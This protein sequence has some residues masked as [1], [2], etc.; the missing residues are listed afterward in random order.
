MC[1]LGDGSSNSCSDACGR[2]N[3]TLLDCFKF[4]LLFGYFDR[5]F[6]LLLFFSL[7]FKFL[8]CLF[9]YIDHGLGRF[10]CSCSWNCACR[11]RQRILN[12]VVNSLRLS[13][14]ITRLL[15]PAIIWTATALRFSLVLLL[16]AETLLTAAILLTAAVLLTAAILVRAFIVLI[17]AKLLLHPAFQEL[18]VCLGGGLGEGKFTGQC[19]LVNYMTGLK[20]N[21]IGGHRLERRNAKSD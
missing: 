21:A 8:F 6:E 19:C 13:T 17:A 16:I 18:R 2:S 1:Y 11:A 4:G 5:I 15:T 10:S 20:W 14:S 3:W 9:L 7:L 12:V